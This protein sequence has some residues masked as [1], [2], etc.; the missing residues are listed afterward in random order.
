MRLYN[1][2]TKLLLNMQ[3]L[4]DNLEE[5]Y[6]ISFFCRWHDE[7]RLTGASIYYGQKELSS[8]LVYVAKAEV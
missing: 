6:N 4:V 2:D 7:Q 5:D 3:I 1:Y 8:D